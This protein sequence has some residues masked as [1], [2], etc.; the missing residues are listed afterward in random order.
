LLGLVLSVGFS[1]G[2]AGLSLFFGAVRDPLYRFSICF[3]SQVLS[4]AGWWEGAAERAGAEGV[5]VWNPACIGSS[6]AINTKPIL[7]PAKA[8]GGIDYGAVRREIQVP[9]CLCGANQ[10]R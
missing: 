1:S 5:L 10:N 6:A 3:F 7:E 4:W 9:F 2:F 8:M